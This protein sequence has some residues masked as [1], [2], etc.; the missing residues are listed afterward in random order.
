MENLN[1]ESLHEYN[2]SNNYGCGYLLAFEA[3]PQA[4]ESLIHEALGRFPP[5]PAAPDDSES[6]AYKDFMY[7]DEPF[8]HAHRSS[9]F[10]VLKFNTNIRRGLKFIFSFFQVQNFLLNEKLICNCAQRVQPIPLYFDETF[11]R[12]TL[13]H[14]MVALC[15]AHAAPIFHNDLK[16]DNIMFRQRV[17]AHATHDGSK[18]CAKIIDWG[19]GGWSK[20]SENETRHIYKPDPEEPPGEATDVFCVGNT[21]LYLF[22]GE[23]W[24]K[25]RGDFH[26]LPQKYKQ[27]LNC[28]WN[29]NPDFQ[30]LD[31]KF[32]VPWNP[33]EDK[34]FKDLVQRMV[35]PISTRRITVKSV[36]QHRFM[37]RKEAGLAQASD[38]SNP[39]VTKLNELLY[40]F[41]PPYLQKMYKARFRHIIFVTLEPCTIHTTTVGQKRPSFWISWCQII[42]Q[43]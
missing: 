39:H 34:D 11:I 31:P 8:L 33:D 24:T 4:T 5:F 9:R 12:K 19:C 10:L 42:S 35:H 6:K 40:N 25:K 32:C 3:A 37:L 22:N 13:K 41:A 21:L 16:P 2:A 26:I 1:G 20:E 30:D 15:H 28:P 27:P 23:E 43:D 36:L 38:V 17:H 14:I 7:L 29:K 18:I